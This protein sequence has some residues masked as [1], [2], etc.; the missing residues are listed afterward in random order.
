MAAPEHVRL[1]PVRLVRRYESPDHVPEPWAPDRVGD[2]EQRQPQGDLFGWQG[3]DQGY[4]LLLANRFRDRLVLTEGED[5]DDVVAGCLGIGLRRAS[6]FGRAPVIHDFTVAFTVW[7]FL[8]AS[9]PPELVALR[10]EKFEEVAHP[11]HY[12][13]RRALVDAI[14]EETLRKPHTLVVQ[15]H[16]RDWRGPLGLA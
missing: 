2:L 8:D 1:P 13:E 15:E 16:A 3:P 6:L 14:P 9:P 7:G 5:P 11:H 4:G 12:L 10:K